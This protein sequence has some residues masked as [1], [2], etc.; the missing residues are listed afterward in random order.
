MTRARPNCNIDLSIV[1]RLHKKTLFAQA[2]QARHR[3]FWGITGGLLSKNAP[4]ARQNH[5]TMSPPSASL[6]HSSGTRKGLRRVAQSIWE[7]WFFL[8]VCLAQP[9]VRSHTIATTT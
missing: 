8:R 1:R 7:S 2:R 4:I 5:K 6:F 3:D 9:C